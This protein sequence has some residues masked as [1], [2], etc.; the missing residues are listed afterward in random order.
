MTGL[1]SANSR[2]GIAIGLVLCCVL[3]SGLWLGFGAN[4]WADEANDTSGAA[5]AP[6]DR[7]LLAPLSGSAGERFAQAGESGSTLSEVTAGTLYLARAVYNVFVTTEVDTSG[8]CSLDSQVTLET[9]ECG[10]GLWHGIRWLLMDSVASWKYWLSPLTD[11][12][13]ALAFTS[14]ASE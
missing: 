14:V 9:S 3:V 5:S 7:Y 8:D 6:D 2:R 1:S 10:G 4:V 13:G 12:V 11:L